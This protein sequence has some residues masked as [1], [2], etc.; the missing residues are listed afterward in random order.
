M[1]LSEAAG[2]DAEQVVLEPRRAELLL[3]QDEPGERV[4]G[5][6]HP[7]RRLEA[8]LEAGALAIVAQRPHHD[9]AHRQGGVDVFLAGRGLDEIGARLHR[10]HAGGVDVAQGLEVAGGEDGLQVGRAA[11]LAHR[12]DLVV[13]RAPF[14]VEHMGA[15]DDDVDF[16]GALADRVSDLGEP[17]LE[18]R[19]A[20]GKAGGDRG[21]GNSRSRQGLDGR[22]D[23]GGI[24]ADRADLRRVVGEAERADQIL[25]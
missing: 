21:D 12:G 20:G 16:A 5:A 17:L 1:S 11:G 9:E 23:H 6:A 15:G 25:A 24:D 8:D 7:A 18:R 22:R 19:Q 10:D 4:L 2:A 14:A 13:E 3:H